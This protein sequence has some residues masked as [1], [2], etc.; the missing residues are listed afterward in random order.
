MRIPEY[1]AYHETKPH[2]D[3]RFPY[4]TYPCSIPLDFPSVP[5]H[6][7]EEMEIIYIKKG[8]GIVS[9][10]LKPIRVKAGDLALIL[11]GH[12]HS[13][14]SW[15]LE[16]M[17]YE[18]IIFRMDLLLSRRSDLCGQDFWEPLF[19]QE[20]SLPL[21]VTP[22]M[23]FY[24]ELVSCIDQADEVCKT[25]PP[26]YPF[27]IKGCLFRFFYLLFAHHC[28][29]RSLPGKDRLRSLDKLKQTI[30]YIDQ[31]YR[32]KITVA[33]I[34][35]FLNISASHFMKYFK[36]TTG[37]SFIAY[38]NDYRLTMASRM[39]LTSSASILEVAQE[40]GF[41]NLSYFNRLFKEKYR[42]TP[43]QYRRQA[44]R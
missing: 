37:S 27:A 2:G 22:E 29:R 12:L 40:T 26:A 44:K 25:F 33:D 41:E 3:P 9:V 15:R 21:C 32:E 20:L 7:H 43:S 31:H 1:E 8:Q 6:W 14:Q 16:T 13:I 10:D 17:E 36:K 28:Q 4:T 30:T 11:P 38:L 35:A 39:L 23:D 42:L 24:Q 18:N 19:A 34:S 5:L